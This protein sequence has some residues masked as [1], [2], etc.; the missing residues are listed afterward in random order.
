MTETDS[1]KTAGGGNEDQR[2]RQLYDA[3]EALRFEDTMKYSVSE[4][5]LERSLRAFYES[6]PETIGDI[7]RFLEAEDYENYTIRV[8]ALKSG[9]RLIGATEISELAARLEACGDLIR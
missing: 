5:L 8:H 6:L 4:E 9:A 2:L 3:I 1:R 7:R